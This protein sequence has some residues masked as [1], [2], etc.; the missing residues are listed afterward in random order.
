MTLRRMKRSGGN[1]GH[2]QSP[3]RQQP[4]E[5]ETSPLDEMPDDGASEAELPGA[6]DYLYGAGRSVALPKVA[7]IAKSWVLPICIMRLQSRLCDLTGGPDD[8]DLMALFERD[9][10]ELSIGV[11][12]Q[13]REEGITMAAAE[14]LDSDDDE[15]TSLWGNVRH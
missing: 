7:R 12:G 5:E 13:G 14:G 4:Q 1:N 2:R 9:L 10:E 8:P 15:G 6:W 11:E 3:A